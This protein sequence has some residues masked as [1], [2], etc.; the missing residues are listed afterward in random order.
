VGPPVRAVA[1][2]SLVTSKAFGVGGT[3]STSS[4]RCLRKTL[5]N[6]PKRRRKVQSAA[7]MIA[8]ELAFNAEAVGQY[9]KGGLVMPDLVEQLALDAWD[10]FGWE[11]YAYSKAGHKDLWDEVAATY[12]GLRR[13]QKRGAHPPAGVYLYDLSDR[14]KAAPY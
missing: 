4:L 5:G 2:I 6:E 9:E 11:S 14:L 7:T 8:N 1:E 10:R 12:D 13:T 3:A